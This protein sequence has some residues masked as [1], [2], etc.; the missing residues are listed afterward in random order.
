MLQFSMALVRSV[1]AVEDLFWNAK[2]LRMLNSRNWK[3]KMCIVKGQALAGI[4]ITKII[5]VP[6]FIA[7]CII[8]YL[9]CSLQVIVIFFLW[10]MP[11]E[12]LDWSE[13]LAGRMCLWNASICQRCWLDVSWFILSLPV[14]YLGLFFYLIFANNVFWLINT[15]T[16]TIYWIKIQ[17]ARVS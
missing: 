6:L 7:Y 1:D 13:V 9:M 17:P 4:Y 5:T 2:R 14:M 15:Q 3:K 16:Y 10:N 8:Y 12:C 11:L